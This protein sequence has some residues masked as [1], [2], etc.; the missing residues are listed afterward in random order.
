M[1]K[2]TKSLV[3]CKRRSPWPSCRSIAS[4]C[5][6]YKWL[7]PVSRSNQGQKY[8][9]GWEDCLLLF[10]HRRLYEEYF[11]SERRII[12]DQQKGSKRNSVAVVD[13]RIANQPEGSRAVLLWR[14]LRR[15]TASTWTSSFACRAMALPLLTWHSKL[16]HWFQ[17]RAPSVIIQEQCDNRDQ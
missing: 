8:T 17:E 7:G 12:I 15:W 4:T 10:C 16:S 5:I 13:C 9:A 3:C 6:L 2:F 1:F 14:S 11:L